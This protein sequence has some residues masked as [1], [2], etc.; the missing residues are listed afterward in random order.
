MPVSS[1][2]TITLYSAG[3]EKTA[4]YRRLIVPWSFLKRAIKLS[5]GLSGDSVTEEQIDE[6]SDLLVEFFG[7]VFKRADLEA[8]ADVSEI[9]TCFQSIVNKARGLLPNP[10]PPAA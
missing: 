10:T 4:E 6:I 2:I 7:N 1:A 3:D 5:K 8:G 9:L